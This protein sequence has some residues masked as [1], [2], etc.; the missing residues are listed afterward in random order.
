MARLRVVVEELE[1]ENDLEDQLDTEEDQDGA[2]FETQN[3]NMMRSVGVAEALESLYVVLESKTEFTPTEVQLTRIASEMAVAGTG[4]E[5]HT[6]VPSLENQMPTVALEG[7]ADRIQ[8][9]LTNIVKTASNIVNALK[10]Y[11]QRVI[12]RLRKMKGRLKSIEAAIHKLTADGKTEAKDVTVKHRPLF[13]IG[14]NNQRV[15]SVS[16]LSKLFK[17]A[18]KNSEAHA[19]AVLN[20]ARTVSK[21]Y[22]LLRLM[23]DLISVEATGR[24]FFVDTMEFAKGLTKQS[25]MKQHGKVNGTDDYQSEVTLGGRIIYV[26]IPSE[27]RYDFTDFKDIKRA[28]NEFRCGITI[29]PQDDD[30]KPL[31]LKSVKLSDLSDMADTANQLIMSYIENYERLSDLLDNGVRNLERVVNTAVNMIVGGAIGLVASNVAPG[32]MAASAVGIGRAVVKQYAVEAVRELIFSY[33]MV[34]INN[35]F[36][37][38][39]VRSALEVVRPAVDDSLFFLNEALT[40]SRWE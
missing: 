31:E 8:I 33:K 26:R 9:I 6:L 18:T 38:S 16:E 29:L 32:T 37:Y 4:I 5:A 2:D 30:V 35:A 20:N 12:F 40:R 24:R 17:V 36:L 3:D 25:K 13:V 39:V 27:D 7:I 23:K 28:A 10:G 19:L 21:D 14:R 34:T 11:V 1:V 22:G 15:S